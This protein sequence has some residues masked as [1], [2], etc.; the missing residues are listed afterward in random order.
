MKDENMPMFEV[1]MLPAREGD[2]IIL[3][4]GCRGAERSLLVDGGRRATSAEISRRMSGRPGFELLVVSHIDRDHIEGILALLQSPSRPVVKEVWFNGYRHVTDTEG[5]R[6]APQGEILSGLLAG[7]IPWNTQF[8]QKAVSIGFDDK[9]P[10]IQMPDGLTLTLLS[11]DMG[12]LRKLEPRWISECERAGMIA[13]SIGERASRGAKKPPPTVIDLDALLSK[14]FF[15]DDSLPNGTSI[16][17][18]AEYR[19][20]RVL[21]AADAHEDR[22]LRSIRALRGNDSRLR[23]DLFKVAHH[24]SAGNIS[25][26]L[27]EEIDCSR[28]AVSSDGS[29]H[30]LPDAEAIARIVKYGGS[31]CELNFNYRTPYTSAWETVSIDAS[32]RLSVNYGVNGY[33]KLSII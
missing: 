19:E 12:K 15:P 32:R 33:L 23:L 8:G 27:L 9:L 25:R 28:Y 6:S 31:T 11:P 24:G 18:L 21:L 7:Q 13:G 30:G 5:E 20:R 3:T 4:Y 14:P 26:A 10:N 22:L 29:H 16:A 1:E 2:C 17:L